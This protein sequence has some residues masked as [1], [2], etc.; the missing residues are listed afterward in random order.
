MKRLL[1]VLLFV[2][3]SVFAD[4]HGKA[5][6]PIIFTI[7]IDL[8]CVQSTWCFDHTNI[9]T[10]AVRASLLAFAFRHSSVLI[11]NEGRVEPI[12]SR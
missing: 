7:D 2:V 5:D 1:L 9:T 4:D 8:R 3:P 11:T 6:Q 12:L 10:L